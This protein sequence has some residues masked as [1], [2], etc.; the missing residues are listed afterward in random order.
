M[1]SIQVAYCSIIFHYLILAV[2]LAICL[3]LDGAKDGI[4]AFLKPD[5][6]ELAKPA[7]RTEWF[8]F[9]S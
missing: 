3:T 7:V 8:I 6:E 9:S 2:V 5:F 1:F 4:M